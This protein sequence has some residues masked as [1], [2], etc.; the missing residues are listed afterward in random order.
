MWGVEELW[1]QS[2]ARRAVLGHIGDGL[3]A[4]SMGNDAAVHFWPGWGGGRLGG[5][6]RAAKNVSL[7][8]WNANANLL[9]A[10]D[11]ARSRRLA[12]LFLFA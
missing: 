11:D 1:L 12:R 5:S 4:Q 9:F 8:V 10:I 7:N 2:E 3:P 6:R